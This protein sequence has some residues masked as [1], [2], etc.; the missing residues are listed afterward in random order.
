M[1]VKKKVDITIT[2]EEDHLEWIQGIAEQYDFLDESKAIRVLFDYAIEDGDKEEIF[3]EDNMRCR[4][5]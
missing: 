1:S 3:S 4:H 5:C 2:V